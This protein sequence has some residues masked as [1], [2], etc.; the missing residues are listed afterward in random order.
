VTSRLLTLLRYLPEYNGRNFK[1]GEFSWTV[2]LLVGITRQADARTFLSLLA[3]TAG[4][5]PLFSDDCSL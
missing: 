4:S 5:N 1:A 3:N 2:T